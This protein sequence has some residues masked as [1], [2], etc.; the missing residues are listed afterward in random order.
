V[1]ECELLSG[2]K[3]RRFEKPRADM[4]ICGSGPSLGAELF[5]QSSTMVFL[6]QIC[7]IVAP[8]QVIDFSHSP[9]HRRWQLTA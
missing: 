6:I 4:V 3:V 5:A 8:I 7:S 1:I 9:S 2:L